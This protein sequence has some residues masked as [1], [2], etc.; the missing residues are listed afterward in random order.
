MYKKAES[1]QI[2]DKSISDNWLN[3]FLVANPTLAIV[4]RLIIDNYAIKKENVLIICIRNTSLEI[5]DHHE[6]KIIPGRYD[7]YKEKLFFDSPSGRKILKK[8]KLLNKH[9]IIYAGGA[10]RE[11]NWL[12]KKKSCKGHVYIEEGQAAYFNYHL[13]SFNRISFAQKIKNNFRNRQTVIDG[14]GF[15]FR[16]DVKACIGIDKKSFPKV[17]KSKKFI[18]NNFNDIKKYYIPKILGVKTLG[19]TCSASR[20]H[21]KRDV[22]IMLQKL[23]NHLPEDSIIKPH[24][25]FTSTKKVYNEFLN[26]YNEINVKKIKL[27]RSDVII[28]LE[29]IHEKKHIIGPQSSLSIYAKKLG[30]KY[31]HIKLFD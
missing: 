21:K 14:E 31:D 9:F 12:L 29:M 23:I 10:S 3:V 6:L 5:F 26:V 16:D 17:P 1:P 18:L 30:S 25:S 4:S 22:K 8:V 7:R 13:T 24:P 15:C 27:C 2:I 28:E 19:L 20:V 11:V